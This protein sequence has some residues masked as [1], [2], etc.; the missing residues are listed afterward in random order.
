M[1]F[2]L[3][4]D[5]NSNLPALEAVLADIEAWDDIGAVYHLGD[6]GAMLRGPTRRSRSCKSAGSWGSRATTTLRWRPNTSTA[7][8]RPIA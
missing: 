1:K 2:A 4:S 8:V 5:V 7:V 6:L 3:I